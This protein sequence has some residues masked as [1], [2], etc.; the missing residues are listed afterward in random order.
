MRSAFNVPGCSLAIALVVLSLVDAS[1][2]TVPQQPMTMEQLE[3]M[4]LDSHPATVERSVRA[5]A[6][7]SRAQQAGAFPNPEIGYV[8]EEIPLQSDT[9]GGRHGFFVEQV[10]PLG[11]KRGLSRTVFEQETRRLE[12]SVNVARQALLVRVRQ[13]AYSAA[14]AARRV[15]LRDRLSQLA[16]E[17]VTTARQLFNLGTVDQ[18]DVLEAETEADLA[19]LAAEEAR[20]DQQRIWRMLG[21]AV[22]A[23]DLPLQPLAIDLEAPL[24]DIQ[25]EAERERLIRDSPEMTVLVARMDRENAA[26]QREQREPAPDLF[27]RGAPLYNRDP[28]DSASRAVGWEASFEV[29]V[30]VPLFN[31]NQ[32]TIAAAASE[33]SA[34]RYA[35]ETAK[36]DLE[37]RLASA[38]GD[39]VNARRRAELLKHEALPRAERAYELYLGRYRQMAAPYPR[40]LTTQRTLF[41]LSVAYV[42]ALESAW[43]SAALIAGNLVTTVGLARE[44]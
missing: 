33:A 37:A 20:N 1:A 29:G 38:F 41:E 21:A 30:R 17:T 13:L 23:P 27:V 6:A 14:A 15:E 5:D 44:R 2:Q 35:Y 24:P 16:T 28:R 8:G 18:P 7:R 11:G 3:K 12:A 40:V 4:M 9:P 25:L 19:R 39:Y 36:L 31:R 10:I 26:L 42:D 22:D 43:R 32:G 34:A